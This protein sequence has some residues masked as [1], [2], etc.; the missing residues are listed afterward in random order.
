MR[1]VTEVTGWWQLTV[2]TCWQGHS[3]GDDRRDSAHWYSCDSCDSCVS[4]LL[5]EKLPFQVSIVKGVSFTLYYARQLPLK[6]P[7]RNNRP[8][9]ACFTQCIFNRYPPLQLELVFTFIIPH[10]NLTSTHQHI[11][12]FSCAVRAINVTSSADFALAVR[13]KWGF[14]NLMTWSR[15]RNYLRQSRSC[16]CHW[17]LKFG[18]QNQQNADILNSDHFERVTFLLKRNLDQVLCEYYL[19]SFGL[20]L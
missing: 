17:K 18:L 9:F 12:L 19:A 6:F 4:Y 5:D 8:H 13:E 2:E 1:V 7:R 14:G 20:H 16:L 10:S 3:N 11:S 15:V